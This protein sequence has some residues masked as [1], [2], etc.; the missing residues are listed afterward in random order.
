MCPCATRLAASRESGEERSWRELG[1]VQRNDERVV[2]VGW[3]DA[4]AYAGWLSKVTGKVSQFEANP[5]PACSSHSATPALL[6]P[7]YSG[8]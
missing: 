3:L 5:S 8:S 2:C 7:A 6:S 1:F 4:K